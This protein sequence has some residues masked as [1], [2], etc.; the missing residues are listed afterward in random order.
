MLQELAVSGSGNI[1]GKDI[2]VV[3]NEAKSYGLNL[4]STSYFKEYKS[5]PQDLKDWRNGFSFKLE[6]IKEKGN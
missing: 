3:I 5:T 1:I 6:A 4:L 2:N